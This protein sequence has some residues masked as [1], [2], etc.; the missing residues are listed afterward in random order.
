MTF[1]IC[2]NAQYEILKH[3]GDVMPLPRMAAKHYLG[4][5]LIDPEIDFVA[6]AQSFGVEAHRVT[7]P[8]ELGERVRASLL[9]SKP[10]L[11]DVP[12]AR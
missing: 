1:I 12:L 5:D 3:C 7:D 10:Q 2:N 9:S 11:F 4:L 8:D 6:L